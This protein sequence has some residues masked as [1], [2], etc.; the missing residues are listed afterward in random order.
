MSIP[1]KTVGSSTGGSSVTASETPKSAV[2]LRS[3]PTELTGEPLAAAYEKR[4]Q[5]LQ[6]SLKERDQVV[7]MLTQRLEQAA[8]QL[9]AY[10]TRQE[11]VVS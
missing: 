11:P 9:T 6:E 8:D 3:A 2:A 1:T 4:V 10:L 7:Q 5:T